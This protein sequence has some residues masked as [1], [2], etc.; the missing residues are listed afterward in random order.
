MRLH[1]FVGWRDGTIS[2]TFGFRH[3]AKTLI[4]TFSDWAFETQIFGR[5]YIRSGHL[6]TPR[7]TQAM[8]S[9]CQQLNAQC[10]RLPETNYQLRFH[11]KP[12]PI[13]E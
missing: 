13:G 6:T 8:Q 7:Y 11:V 1:D 3:V 4:S 10:P 9:L 2:I 12:R 5:K